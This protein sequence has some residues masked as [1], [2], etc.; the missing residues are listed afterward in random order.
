[1]AIET[2]C[3]QCERRFE[4]STEDV[5]RGVWQTCPACRQSLADKDAAVIARRITVAKRIQG[6]ETY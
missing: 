2:T 5:R 3:R 4:A 6:K 1:M